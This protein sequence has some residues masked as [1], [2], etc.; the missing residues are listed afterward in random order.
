M[1]AKTSAKN[2]SKKL[3]A[4]TKPKPKSKAKKA[5]KAEGEEDAEEGEEEEEEDE[6]EEDEE[7]EEEEE[8]R[9]AKCRKVGGNAEMMF[10]G[11]NGVDIGFFNQRGASKNTKEAHHNPVN[12]NRFRRTR[13]GLS[14]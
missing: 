6:V 9:V 7:D 5:K 3:T 10:S 11:K 13:R 8:E 12:L 2:R 1:L 4:K 14:A